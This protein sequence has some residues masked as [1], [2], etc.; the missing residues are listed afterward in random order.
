MISQNTFLLFNHHLIIKMCFLYRMHLNFLLL[1]PFLLAQLQ[2]QNCLKRRMKKRKRRRTTTRKR[3]WSCCSCW[4]SCWHLPPSR[5]R[6]SRVWLFDLT[7]EGVSQVIASCLDLVMAVWFLIGCQWETSWR[8]HQSAWTLTGSLVY[9][10]L[11]RVTS[12]WRRPERK[13]NDFSA[14]CP[15]SSHPL[16]LFCL[17]LVPSLCLSS[18]VAVKVRTKRKRRS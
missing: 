11:E 2:S 9:L 3:S 1:T 4:L 15:L 16:A 13:R 6:R 17:S 10:R 12:L 7:V 14:L 8:W 5:W 18:L